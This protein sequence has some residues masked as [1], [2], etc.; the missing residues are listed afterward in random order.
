MSGLVERLELIAAWHLPGGRTPK[1]P[2][3]DVYTTVAEAAT[4]ITSLEAQIAQLRADNAALLE[5][6]GQSCRAADGILAPITAEIGRYLYDWAD[7]PNLI[8]KAHDYCVVVSAKAFADLYN[9]TDRALLAQH[10]EKT[11]D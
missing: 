8:E 1:Q 10:G 9:A 6:Y 4:C 5:A 3:P 11:N 2:Y 7:C